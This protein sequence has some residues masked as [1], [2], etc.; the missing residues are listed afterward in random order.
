MYE[1]IQYKSCDEEKPIH[2]SKDKRQLSYLCKALIEQVEIS[3]MLWFFS[4]EKNIDQDQKINQRNDKC[5]CRDPMDIPMITYKVF[6]KCDGPGSCEKIV[7]CH[8][9][10]PH[11][12]RFYGIADHKEKLQRV[13]K[14]WIE[15]V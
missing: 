14:L 9:S 1:G 11:S 15:S 7:I 4:D 6:S 10:F 8:A 3:G 2:V 13:V 12:L 5:L